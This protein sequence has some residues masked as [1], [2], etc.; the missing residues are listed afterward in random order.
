MFPAKRVEVTVR[1]P[2]AW[3]TTIGA[4]G[5]GFSTV[6]QAMVKLR[7]S[8][9][10]PKDVYYYGAFAPNT[11]FSTYCGYGCV[12]GLCGLLTYPSD[13]TGRACVG[14]GFSGSDSAQTAAHE[15]GHAHGRAHA[16]CSTS[17]YDS[18][19]P[20]SGGA[21]GAW[22]WDLVQKKLL[23]PSTTKDFMGYCRPSWVSD[24]TFR[25]LGT[26]MS[27][28]SGSADVIVPSDSSSAGAPRA[29]RFVDVAG[30]GRL[31]WGD[32]VMLPEPPLAEPHTVRWLDASGTVLESATGHYYPYDDL[33]G[34][35]MLVPEAPIGAASVAVGGF[36]ASGVEIRIPRP[37]P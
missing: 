29:Y 5:T 19:Y 37:A 22:G 6:L 26:R 28:V 14:V 3:T 36:A 12:T 35:Y 13:A 27:Y 17:D 34:G 2:V 30:D 16:P 21:I 25:A 15:I 1:A 9:G 11:S 23:N 31:T 33:A 24:Y 20:Y 7:A 18:A 10:A 8:D 4:N 32:R